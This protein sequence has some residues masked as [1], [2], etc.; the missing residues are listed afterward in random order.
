MLQSTLCTPPL[1][2]TKVEQHEHMHEIMEFLYGH[3]V[4]YIRDLH[5]PNYGLYKNGLPKEYPYAPRDV[6]KH[7][8]ELAAKE[9]E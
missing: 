6:I 7:A 5:S 1:L 9:L 4:W 2:L 8:Y 3:G